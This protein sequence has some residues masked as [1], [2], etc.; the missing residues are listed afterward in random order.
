[1]VKSSMKTKVQHEIKV[2]EGNLEF[3]K[4]PINILDNYLS[5]T[6]S[7]NIDNDFS[8]W[9]KV[10]EFKNTKEEANQKFWFSVGIILGR[11][12]QYY[13]YNSLKEINTTLTITLENE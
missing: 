5:L 9:F 8:P 13:N 1:M 2:I 4:L 6:V 3:E 11:L 10:T 7:R 12:A